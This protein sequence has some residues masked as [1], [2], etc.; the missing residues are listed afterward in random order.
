MRVSP[1]HRDE[2]AKASWSGARKGGGTR[3]LASRDL[4]KALEKGGVYF[5]G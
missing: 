1:T 2:V 5:E 3:N 4:R